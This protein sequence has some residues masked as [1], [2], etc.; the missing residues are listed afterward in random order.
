[1][2]PLGRWAMVFEP[3]DFAAGEDS[4]ACSGSL[5]EPRRCSCTNGCD[6]CGGTGYARCGAPAIG[7]IGS[8]ATCQE[9]WGPTIRRLFGLGRDEGLKLTT[10]PAD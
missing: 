3:G 1:M 9:H 2:K 4:P 6:T 8:E 5:R 7:Y 10:G